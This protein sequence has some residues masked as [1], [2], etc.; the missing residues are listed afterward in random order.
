MGVSRDCLNFPLPEWRESIQYI[1]LQHTINGAI[2]KKPKIKIFICI[3]V[4]VLQ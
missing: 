2:N 3:Y 1:H 4:D